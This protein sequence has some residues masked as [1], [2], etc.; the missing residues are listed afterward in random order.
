M[1]FDEDFAEGLRIVGAPDDGMDVEAELETEESRTRLHDRN[2][3]HLETYVRARRAHMR[4][5]PDC[6]AAPLCCGP[7]VASA[8]TF[9]SAIQQVYPRALLYSAIVMLADRDAE[10]AD[11]RARLMVMD[12]DLVDAQGSLAD[13]QTELGVTLARL[14]ACDEM[15]DSAV[16]PV[17]PTE[18][19]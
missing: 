16:P 13:T 8:L 9:R 5:V 18:G 14:A 15:L 10:I 4:L 1:T 6:G 17:L 12:A 2:V 7:G 3:R 19:S 11:L